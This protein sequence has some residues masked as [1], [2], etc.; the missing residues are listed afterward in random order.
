MN[1]PVIG[2]VI[3]QIDIPYDIKSLVKTVRIQLNDNNVMKYILDGDKEEDNHTTFKDD[4]SKI[5]KI[6]AQVTLQNKYLKKRADYKTVIDAVID[7][8]GSIGEDK[9]TKYIGDAANTDLF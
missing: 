7:H 2:L 4:I 8:I 5:N 1:I 6:N 9:I 3:P